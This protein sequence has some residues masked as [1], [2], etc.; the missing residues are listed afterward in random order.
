MILSK[1]FNKYEHWIR[2]IIAI[3]Y[4]IRNALLD[5]LHHSSNG[6]PRDPKDL[7]EQLDKEYNKRKNSKLRNLFEKK[8]LSKEEIKSLLPRSRES[9]SQDWDIPVIIVMIRNFYKGLKPPK[10]E[11]GWKTKKPEDND[12]SLAAYLVLALEIR[13]LFF[14][15]P[16]ERCRPL[17][18]FESQMIYVR[19]ILVGLRYRNLADFVADDCLYTVDLADIRKSIQIGLNST[20][21]CEKCG[22][23]LD[24]NKFKNVI[25]D[26]TEELKKKEREGIL[27]QAITTSESFLMIFLL[28]LKSVPI[29]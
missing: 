2:C 3:N 20:Y 4:H 28:L 14:H 12:F 1:L 26:I 9:D 29:C 21:S 17:S 24:E 8:I 25:R 6:L 22:L 19:D 27:L 18:E 11:N 16:M 23:Q 5:I 7:Y 10:G 13:N 15:N